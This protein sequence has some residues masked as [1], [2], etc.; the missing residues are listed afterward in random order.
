MDIAIRACYL[1][2]EGPQVARP[3]GMSGQPRGTGSS[4]RRTGL[5]AL[6]WGVWGM[7]RGTARL[8]SVCFV[9]VLASVLFLAAVCGLAPAP[10]A[11]A[12]PDR[13][14]LRGH[15]PPAVAQATPG[16]VCRRPS[17][18]PSPSVC[19]CG[20][21]PHWRSCSGKSTTLAARISIDFSRRRNSRHGLGRPRR[22]IGR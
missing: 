16:G 21:R 2:N 10:G 12:G 7:A 19:P 6:A 1:D 5:G 15:V 4:P 13:A 8:L 20:I 22:I 3:P 17:A 11:V 9:K 18:W 14:T